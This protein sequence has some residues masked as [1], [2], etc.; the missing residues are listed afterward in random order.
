M[1]GLENIGLGLTWQAT[2]DS[3]LRSFDADAIV[4][5]T[6]PLASLRLQYFATGILYQCDK[7]P[8]EK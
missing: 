8:P 3:W 2:S 6:V 5:G 1:T 7:N 4:E